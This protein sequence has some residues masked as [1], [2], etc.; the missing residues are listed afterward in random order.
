MLNAHK[1]ENQVSGIYSRII[2]NYDTTSISIFSAVQAETGA[3]KTGTIVDLSNYSNYML[4]IDSSSVTT[5]AAGMTGLEVAF[6]TRAVS[7]AA[8]LRIALQSG[9]NAEGGTLMKVE[10]TGG[11]TSGIVPLRDLKVEAKNVSS[12]ATAT[13]NAYIVAK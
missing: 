11:Y 5:V 12:S 10:G 7:G 8:W 9:I 6:F 1:I 3:T 2:S 4:Y 13:L